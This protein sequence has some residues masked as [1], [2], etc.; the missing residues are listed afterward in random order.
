MTHSAENDALAD[1]LVAIRA[2]SFASLI[3][4]SLTRYVSMRDVA[5]NHASFVL[6]GP[7]GRVIPP[8]E[9]GTDE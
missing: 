3:P 8:G 5:I 7:K 9:D 1:A 6:A 4:G 2:A